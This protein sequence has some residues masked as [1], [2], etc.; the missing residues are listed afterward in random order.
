MHKVLI[1]EDDITTQKIVANTVER[2]G[3]IPIISPTGE[4]AYETL[5]SNTGFGLL[6][7]DI[8]MPGMDGRKLVKTLRGTS[9]YKSLP[10][11]MISA[12]IG[13]KEIYS[14]LEM[15]VTYFLAKP[16]DTAE[17]KKY[18]QKCLVKSQAELPKQTIK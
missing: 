15:G 1:A 4:H 5:A 18:I 13:Y 12:V 6:I 14:V 2:L 10:I 16:L 3:H 7:T 8:M 17:L 9:E 11:I